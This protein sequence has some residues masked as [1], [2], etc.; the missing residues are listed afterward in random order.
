MAITK[1]KFNC[2][3]LTRSVPVKVNFIP[4]VESDSQLTEVK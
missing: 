2:A 4:D 1:A 3:P